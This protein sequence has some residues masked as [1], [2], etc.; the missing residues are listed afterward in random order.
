[1]DILAQVLEGKEFDAKTLS[2]LYDY[3]IFTLGE[4]A[5]QIR[6][7]KYDKKVFFNMNRHINPTNICTDV[8]KF[9]AFSASRKNPNP[10]EMTIDE[11][12][13]QTLASYRRGA[14]EVHIVSAHSPNY[15]Y[16][17]YLSC[18]SEVKKAVPNIHLKAMTAA[19]VHYLSK[20]FAKSYQKVL[21]DMVLAGV[22]S[23]P[24]GGAE[25]FDEEVRRRI[26]KGKV[27]STRW[28]EIHSYWHSIGKMSNATMLFGHI[29]NREHRIDHMLRLART[30]CDSQIVES[31]HGG[32]NA[33]IPLLYQRENN[34]LNIKQFPSGQE[35][36]KTISIARIVLKNIPHI[37]AY[38]ATLG[39]NLALVA[40]EFGADDM[41]GTIENESIQSAGGSKSKNGASFDEIVAQIKN[42]GFI[43]V[44][45]DSL[46]NELRVCE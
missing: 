7:S 5:N 36:L 44:E 46:Y 4:A 20:K 24:G 11:I 33:F 38:W 18:F 19:E 13:S 45:R 39:M 35:I 3:D 21:E 23:M 16:E 30:Q 8:C 29:E 43:A 6:A 2:A 17:W 26:C 32:F 14:K 15:S 28:L 34:F 41:D 1:M 25:I 37:K 9:C 10:Y 12:I 31:K 40:Q 22:D 27:D 42:A